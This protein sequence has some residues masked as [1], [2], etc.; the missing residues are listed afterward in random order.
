MYIDNEY[1][2]YL[3]PEIIDCKTMT[4][5]MTHDLVRYLNDFFNQIPNEKDKEVIIQNISIYYDSLNALL[6]NYNME[7]SR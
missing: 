4:I 7:Y 2:K 1:K 6:T 3:N 5:E